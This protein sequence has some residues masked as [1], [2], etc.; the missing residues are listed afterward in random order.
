LEEGFL[1]ENWKLKARSLKPLGRGGSSKNKT[2]L[3]ECESGPGSGGEKEREICRR[4]LHRFKG[5]SLKEGKKLLGKFGSEKE[6]ERKFEI[7]ERKVRPEKAS[8]GIGSETPRE[9]KF[10]IYLRFYKGVLRGGGGER[11]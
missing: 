10:H 8:S 5:N 3:W 7:I 1:E 2:G 6:K 11:G 9:K 4:D